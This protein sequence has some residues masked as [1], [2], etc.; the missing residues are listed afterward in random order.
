MEE[1]IAAGPPI[2]IAGLTLIPVT[3]VSLRYWS[4]EGVA[5]FL[6]IKKPVAVVV[7]SLQ[8]KR[9]FRITGEEVSLEQ[10]AQEVPDLEEM[11][12]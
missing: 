10:L 2:T 7:V 1:K 3:K 4:A 6:G 5:S 12:K 9:A 11:L 8:A